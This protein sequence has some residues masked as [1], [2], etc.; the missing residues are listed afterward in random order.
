MKREGVRLPQMCCSVETQCVSDGVGAM[1][2]AQGGAGGG[3]EARGNPAAINI[4]QCDTQT[5]HAHTRTITR[6]HKYSLFSFLSPTAHAHQIQALVPV[7]HTHICSHVC[8]LAFLSRSCALSC[9]HV[10]PSLTSPVRLSSL[11]FLGTPS[12]SKSEHKNTCMLKT[13]SHMRC[14]C[15]EIKHEEC[16]CGGT[17]YDSLDVLWQS[18]MITLGAAGFCVAMFVAV[19]AV[20]ATM[21]PQGGCCSVYFYRCCLFFPFVQIMRRRAPIRVPSDSY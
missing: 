19:L 16:D 18:F 2:T 17:L 10:C 9:Q 11:S 13:K 20:C 12:T 14:N 1:G 5:R 7:S 4:V 6:P 3:G 21:K 8:S 15:N